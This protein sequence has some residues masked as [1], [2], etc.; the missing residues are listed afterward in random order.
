MIYCDKNIYGEFFLGGNPCIFLY[1]VIKNPILELG[2]GYSWAIYKTSTLR[3]LL[4]FDIRIFFAS[5]RLFAWTYTGDSTI[6]SPSN[7]FNIF[8]IVALYVVMSYC[9]FI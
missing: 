1:M 7:V 6:K 3:I 2:K 5:L 4:F 9:F 8:L